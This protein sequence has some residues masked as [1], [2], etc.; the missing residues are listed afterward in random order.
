MK[1]LFSVLIF[2][3]SLSSFSQKQLVIKGIHPNFYVVHDVARNETYSSIAKLYSVTPSKLADYNKLTLHDGKIYAKTINVP[4]TASNF[5]QKKTIT[6]TELLVP[7]NYVLNANESVTHVSIKYKIPAQALVEINNLT[8]PQLNSRT[9]LTVGFLR[10]SPAVASFFDLRTEPVV[11]TPQIKQ[12]PQIKKPEPTSDEEQKTLNGIRLA[13]KRSDNPPP[14]ENNP[15]VFIKAD[16]LTSTPVVQQDETVTTQTADAS[17]RPNRLKVFVDCSNT[18]CDNSFIKTEINIVDFLLDRVASDVHMLITSQRNGS[19]GS[20]FQ[21]I[22]YGQ[23]KF[24]NTKDTLRFN[25]DPN[26]TENERRDAMVKYIKLGLTPFIA[27]TDYAKDIDIQ[28]KKN[29]EADGSISNS[30]TKDKWN[31]WVF[32]AG[33]NGNINLEEVYKS[34]R[35][36][37]NFSANRTTDK[38]KM[39][40]SS[41]AGQN[42]SKYQYEDSS[43]K[44]VQTIKNS[45][46]QFEHFLVKSLGEHWSTAY[47]ISYS[48]STYSN[49]KNRLRFG[50][51][52]EY[53]IFPYKE[54]NNKFFT[55]RYGVNARRS[56][57]YD[58]TIYNKI[59]EVLFEHELSANL[60]VKQKWGSLNTQ[61]EY[62][63]F[64]HDFKQNN[65]SINLN[66][67]VRITGGLSVYGY[68]F[69]G[70]VHD[71]V[72]LPKGGASELEILTRRR[73]LA[74]Q[75]NFSS[76]FGLSYRFGS[77]L[78]NFVNPRFDDADN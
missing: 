7:V 69:A 64:L 25:V 61:V 65:L 38:I 2:F 4:L 39:G 56:T 37:G 23:N 8:T 19:G 34:S 59:Q 68:T 66:V 11:R 54:V 26:A 71:Q 57:Y 58:T 36:N 47:Q 15:P 20:Q 42:V 35:Y 52:I 16:T 29:N 77:K 46:Y 33:A 9:Q 27:Q 72:Y 51:G 5:I 63:N 75:Y 78:N 13:K 40:F 43:G 6:K 1:I 3:V 60:S 55:I 67:E 44:N 76:G 74:S 50:T 45:N 53:A 10:I 17:L 73:Q 48:N 21:M 12:P 22:F 70:L 32:R 31:Y 24:K 41:N 30:N 49:N 62:S 28:M 18:R 14:I